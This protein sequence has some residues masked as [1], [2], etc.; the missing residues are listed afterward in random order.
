VSITSSYAWS[1]PSVSGSVAH[2]VRVLDRLLSLG[3]LPDE[4]S[5]TP[6]GFPGIQHAF[7]LPT[8]PKFASPGPY[9]M[10]PRAIRAPLMSFLAQLV[11]PDDA[12][13]VHAVMRARL[14]A[15]EAPAS[16]T[17]SWPFISQPFTDL[18]C[19][20]H[21]AGSLPYV[22][23][24]RSAAFALTAAYSARHHIRAP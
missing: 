1:L 24:P 6:P 22:H 18:E 2:D 11:A 13:P 21:V 5:H 7:S 10:S 16:G 23:C 14:S 12:P 19:G 9:P 3:N 17:A 20:T 4:A 15:T 8:I